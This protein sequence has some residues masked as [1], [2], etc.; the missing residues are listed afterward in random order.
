MK[1]YFDE[2]KQV[3]FADPDNC[4][5]WLT[6][7][8]YKD[9]IICACCGGVFEI[10]DVLDMANVEGINNPIHEYGEWIDIS[11]EICGGELP[12]GLEFDSD[13][14]I[15]ESEVDEEDDNNIEDEES[16]EYEAY[17]YEDLE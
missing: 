8:A 4:G 10:E 6:G 16:S 15:I 17:F 13:N 5:E 12:D 9:E 2:P 7:I 11:T 3:V 14:T 1:S